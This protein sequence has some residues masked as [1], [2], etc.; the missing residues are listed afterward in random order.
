ME[1]LDKKQ[2]TKNE[3]FVDT[4]KKALEGVEAEF[5]QTYLLRAKGEAHR[6]I[7]RSLKDD[8][9]SLPFNNE[10]GNTILM[11]EDAEQV[12]VSIISFI[13]KQ[14][15]IL[16]KGGEWDPSL[17]ETVANIFKDDLE[18]FK[19]EI[20]SN[21]GQSGVCFSLDLVTLGPN[22]LPG[23]LRLDRYEVTQDPL[24]VNAVSRLTLYISNGKV[25]IELNPPEPNIHD[26][27]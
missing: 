1:D 19:N 8:L 20:Y 7:L 10:V 14:Q 6:I 9:A 2:I 23:G 5:D 3:I 16:D 11:R 18:V 26:T 22:K 21:S 15:D 24:N 13:T 27:K 4:T 12:V 17:I 25:V